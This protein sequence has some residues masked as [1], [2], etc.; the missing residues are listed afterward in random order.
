PMSAYANGESGGV[1]TVLRAM[2]ARCCSASSLATALD[3]LVLL[4]VL[5]FQGS[6]LD[7]YLIRSNEGSVAWYFWFLADFLV[8][9]AIMC[10]VFFARRHYRRMAQREEDAPQEDCPYPV[11]GRFPLCYVSWLLYS[12]L[13]VAKVVLLF[14]LDVA[15]LLEENARYGVQFLKAVVAASAVVFLLLVEGH[16]DAASQSEQRTYL[17]S[18]CTGTTFELLDSV[19]FLGLLFPNETHLTLTYPL[20][21]AVLALACVNFV[22]PGLALFKLS[23]CEY[24]LRPRPLGLKLLYKLLHLSLVNVPYLAIRVYLWGFFGHDVSLFIVKNLLGIYAGIRALV[25]DLRLYC[26]LLSERGARKRVNEA[27][28]RDPI[29]LK[30]MCDDR[31]CND[32]DDEPTPSRGKAS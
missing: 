11:W 17:R 19:T 26:F 12:L 18:L 13:L 14:R 5:V 22:L 24:G 27:E 6:T 29:E 1:R 25:P 30:V 9:I 3:V 31:R 32:D 28:A 8:V 20:E 23:Q 4:V 10:A 15:Q 21:N 7:F 16:H 2:A